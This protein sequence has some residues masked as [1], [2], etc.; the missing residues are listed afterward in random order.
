MYKT[1]LSAKAAAMAHANRAGNGVADSQRRRTKRRIAHLKRA[2]F[3]VAAM[4]EVFFIHNDAAGRKYWSPVGAPIRIL[5]A[6]GRRRLTVFGAVTDGGRQL[7]RTSTLGFND[8]T[9]V[10]YVRAFSAAS[11]G[12]R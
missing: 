7:F 3:D 8:G 9:F 1:G 12:S 5:H 4:D 11:R 2:R 6:G 10:P